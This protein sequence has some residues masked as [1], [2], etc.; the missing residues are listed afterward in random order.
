MYSFSLS[1]CYFIWIGSLASS[2]A[3]KLDIIC[4]VF[5]IK[6]FACGNEHSSMYDSWSITNMGLWSSGGETLD[7]NF[8][9]DARILE[10]SS[11]K[12]SEQTIMLELLKALTKILRSLGFSR[13]A[14]SI[15]RMSKFESVSKIGLFWTSWKRVTLCSMKN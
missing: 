2:L 6:V 8:R 4:Y 9:R 11:S 15:T 7:L 3:L 12:L 10:A 1:F 14:E 13:S 5:D